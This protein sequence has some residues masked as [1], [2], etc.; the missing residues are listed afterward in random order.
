MVFN[1]KYGFVICRKMYFLYSLYTYIYE[2]IRTI[3]AYTCFLY[4]VVFYPIHLH[5]CSYLYIHVYTY[6][7]MQIHTYTSKYW[8]GPGDRE[9]GGMH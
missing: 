9:G 2:F 4:L 1:D 8:Q 7:Y 6:I 3:H 5:T